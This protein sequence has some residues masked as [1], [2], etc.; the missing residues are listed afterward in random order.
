[1]RAPVSACRRIIQ[2]LAIVVLVAPAYLRS[3]SLWLG[4]YLSSRLFQVPLTDPL[5]AAE[6]TLATKTFIAGLLLSALPL[7]LAAAVLG[8]IFCGWICPLNTVLEMAAYI[9]PPPQHS[10]RKDW[11][12][13]A[14]LGVLLA[15]AAIF[16]IPFFTIVSPIGVISRVFTAGIGP[17][18][19]GIG[20][21]V[22]A[23]WFGNQKFWCRRLCPAG[24]LYGLL[25]CFRL[26]RVRIATEACTQ[27]GDCHQHCSM[28]V[29]VGSSAL[30]DVMNC[31]NC[32]QCVAVCQAKAAAF[33]W[34]IR[35][36][37]GTK[38]DE[39][40]TSVKR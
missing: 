34:R 25:S 12:P 19:I 6:V 20:L 38:T 22:S 2:C 18:M 17:E 11:Q 26:L 8:R 32:G 1:M 10:V 36:K 4:N 16:S 15:A 21:L 27:C 23:E 3:D 5:T 39:L 40:I 29:N 35:R 37:G 7:L 9:K 13:F 24:A 30:L 28:R 14:L 33:D 31:T